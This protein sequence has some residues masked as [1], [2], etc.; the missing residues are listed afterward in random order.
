MSYRVY[1]HVCVCVSW[2]T[3]CC[4]LQISQIFSLADSPPERSVDVENEL[5]KLLQSLRL[6]AMPSLWY[7]IMVD[8]PQL[9]LIQCSKLSTMADT[10]VVIDP[11]FFYQVTVQR[12]PLLPTHPLYARFPGRLSSVTS[13][14][15]LLL[16]LEKYV[17]CQGLPPPQQFRNKS[18]LIFE[19]ASTCEFLIKKNLRSCQSCLALQGY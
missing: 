3:C 17:V 2:F 10:I 16:A 15:D 5:M 19:R 1:L 11:G 7:A 12:Q 8:G 6:T 14:V 4:L 13:V 18:P 9:H